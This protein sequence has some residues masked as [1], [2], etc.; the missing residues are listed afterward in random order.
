M[1]IDVGSCA[2]PADSS[3]SED[4]KPASKQPANQ[5]TG[6]SDDGDTDS[7][8]DSNQQSG[9]RE[10]SEDGDSEQLES[11]GSAG[12]PASHDVSEDEAE[13]SSDESQARDLEVAKHID[14]TR[15]Y[16]PPALRQQGTCDE[17]D[18]VEEREAST[19]SEARA[20]ADVARQIR[21]LLNR[22]AS[23]NLGK[24]ARQVADLFLTVPRHAVIDAIVTSA[25][26]V[27]VHP[28]QSLVCSR[29]HRVP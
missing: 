9:S 17:R 12:P 26:Q 8:I 5:E 22:V 7:A 4:A 27:R 15:K 2:S 21:G 29:S 14:A 24:V 10:S 6:F 3:G 19:A 1:G 28:N 18:D 13:S 16:V 23:A 20:L 25:M 11:P